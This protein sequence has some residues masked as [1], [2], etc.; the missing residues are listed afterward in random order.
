[1]A[2]VKRYLPVFYPLNNNSVFHHVKQDAK[3]SHPQA[4]RNIVF[5]QSLDVA[6]QTIF[7]TPDFF[8]NLR[9]EFCRKLV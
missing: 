8:D 1:M 3:I 7:K 9:G 4:V 2:L 5:L 6:L